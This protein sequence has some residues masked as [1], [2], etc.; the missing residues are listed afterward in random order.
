MNKVG[1]VGELDARCA[2]GDGKVVDWFLDVR[3]R[4][5]HARQYLDL[6]DIAY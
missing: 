6:S 1:I 2:W 3:K 5:I 4:Q